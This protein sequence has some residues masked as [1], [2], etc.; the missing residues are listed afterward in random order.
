MTFQQKNNTEISETS[1]FQFA[2]IGAGA[3][4]T[5]IVKGLLNK[6]IYKASEI[7]FLSRSQEK[8]EKQ[9]KELGI[10]I[11]TSYDELKKQVA[12]DAFLLLGVKPQVMPIALEG[13]I[14]IK[15]S[16]KIISV[17]AGIKISTIEKKFPENKIFRVMPNTPAQISKAASAVSY[18][19]KSSK[20]SIAKVKEIFSAI[21][22]CVEVDEKDLDA[23]T[24]LSGSGPAYVFLMTEAMTNAGIKLGLSKEVAETLAR[25][26]VYGAASLMIE[27]GESAQDLRKKVTSPNGT[28]QAG[29]ENFQANNFEEIVEKALSAAKNR[30]I[31][32]S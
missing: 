29:I 27:S 11:T 30:S 5:A 28:T 31:E 20:E 15:D 17:A 2:V 14:G 21:G 1:K 24:A 22:I 13:L 8:L 26:T 23:V 4:A 18:N 7:I 19:A 25:Q 10:A 12:D 32:L 6:N 16:N 3:M 9:N